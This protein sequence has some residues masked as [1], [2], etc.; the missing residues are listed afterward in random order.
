MSSKEDSIK[1]G[2]W[3][4]QENCEEVEEPEV[5]SLGATAKD[6]VIGKG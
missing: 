2:R 6:R 3:D 4:I 5:G 1:N